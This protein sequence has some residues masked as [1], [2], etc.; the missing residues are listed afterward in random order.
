MGKYRIIGGKWR[1]RKLNFIDDSAI[2]PTPDRVRETLFNWLAPVIADAHCLDVFAGSGALSFEALSRG[3]KSVVTI[4]CNAA[5]ITQLQAHALI[6]ACV[7]QLQLIKNHVPDHGLL[8]DH[9]FSIAFID[10]PFKKNLIEPVV[11]WLEDENCLAPDALIY[12]ES[13]RGLNPL[14]VPA[15]W[16]ALHCKTAGQVSYSL[17]KRGEPCNKTH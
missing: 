4:D 11:N 7:S 15:N 6:L 2:R 10:P 5:V 13:E 9:H 1:G 3:A 16:Q 8:Q 12:L 17:Y 14:P